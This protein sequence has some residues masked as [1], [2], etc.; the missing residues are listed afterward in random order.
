MQRPSARW[1]CV[2]SPLAR[3]PRFP[4]SADRQIARPVPAVHEV[5]SQVHQVTEAPVAMSASSAANDLRGAL[6]VEVSLLRPLDAAIWMRHSDS[7]NARAVRSQVGLAVTPGGPRTSYRGLSEGER[8]A[9]LLL[10]AASMTEQ[11]SAC[12]LGRVSTRE[13]TDALPR[14]LQGRSRRG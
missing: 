13:P 2:P 11:S 6:P 5:A 14:A 10:P 8:N 4:M 7:D 3:L 9:P 12:L 1:P